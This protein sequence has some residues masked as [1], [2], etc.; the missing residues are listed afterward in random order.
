MNS[1][2]ICYERQNKFQKAGYFDGSETGTFEEN[3]VSL[4]K[5]EKLKN[6]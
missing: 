1:K 5:E 3:K 6:A 4:T 2:N